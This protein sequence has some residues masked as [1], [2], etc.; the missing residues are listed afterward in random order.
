MLEIAPPQTLKML[1]FV[2]F[3]DCMTV[4]DTRKF[5]NEHWTVLYYSANFP[6]VSKQ[7]L[8][9]VLCDVGEIAFGHELLFSKSDQEFK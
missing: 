2:S 1:F 7:S 5:D 9:L 6:S 4:C 3:M 8:S